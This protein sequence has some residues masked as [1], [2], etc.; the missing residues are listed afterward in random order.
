MLRCVLWV[1]NALQ[2]LSKRQ[3][4]GMWSQGQELVTGRNGVCGL[5][6]SP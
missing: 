4:S 5:S 2:S 1:Q 3:D 6:V